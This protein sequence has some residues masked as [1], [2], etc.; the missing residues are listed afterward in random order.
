VRDGSAKIIQIVRGE[1]QMA[2]IAVVLA[3]LVQLAIRPAVLTKRAA[4]RRASD[5]IRGYS[6][7]MM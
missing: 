4:D 6:V 5:D 7:A 1:L 3:H 2:A